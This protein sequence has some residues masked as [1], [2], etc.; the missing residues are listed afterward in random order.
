MT[1]LWDIDNNDCF[2]IKRSTISMI[3]QLKNMKTL[4]PFYMVFLMGLL[5]LS[6]CRTEDDLFIDPPL[7]EAIASNSNIA[8][9]LKNTSLNDGSYDNIIDNASCFS[10][11]LPVTVV[12]NGQ[13]VT[14]STEV[15]LQSIEDIFDLDLDDSDVLE[16]E[17]PITLISSNF[18]STTVNSS[19]ELLSLTSQCPAENAIDDDIECIDFVYPVKASAFNEN[20]EII[21]TFDFNN[22]EDLFDF[23]KD[24]DDYVAARLIFPV[25]L[26]LYDGTQIS[27]DSL[28]E[29]ETVLEN[30]EDI[31]DEDDDNDYDDDDCDDCSTDDV[32]NI[33]SNC[34]DWT[35]DKLERNDNDLE[36]FYS[37][38]TFAFMTSGEVLVTSSQGNL[39][40]NWQIS[41]DS[42]NMTMVI[43]IPGLDDFNDSWTVHEIRQDASEG[44]LELRTGDDRVRF[45]STCS[46]G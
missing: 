35:V 11:V 43:N 21:E 14:V 38:Y 1:F 6:S 39:S 44:R 46:G 36:D 32:N 26:V 40:G 18:V 33:F 24:I 37:S 7:E 4:N 19:T 23:I 29:L 25:N 34:M 27:V 41:G 8:N 30:A 42:N 5:V 45:Y 3:I 12:A 22:D 13:E 31:C 10:V 2:N 20:N 15:D 17:F 16:I 9:L 28:S